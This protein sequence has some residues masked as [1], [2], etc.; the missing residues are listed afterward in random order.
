MSLLGN[1]LWIILGGGIVICLQYLFAGV[2]LCCTI[3]GIPFGV[4]CFKLGIF[5]LLPFGQEAVATSN[6]TSPLLLILNV[7]WVIFFGIGILLSHLMFALLC[8][9]TII[10]IPFAWQHL[11]LASLGLWPFGRDIREIR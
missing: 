6:T 3:I 11:K 4:Q 7:L 1:I 2:V 9:I 5:S 10:G 8:G